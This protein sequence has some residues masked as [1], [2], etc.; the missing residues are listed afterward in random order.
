MAVAGIGAKAEADRSIRKTARLH[1]RIDRGVVLELGRLDPGLEI[2]ERLDAI[3]HAEPKGIRRDLL[4][5]VGK[6]IQRMGRPV[7]ALDVLT[8]D[9]VEPAGGP[10]LF[11]M[12][13][14]AQ[15]VAPIEEARV[16]RP[17]GRAAGFGLSWKIGEG[18]AA[19]ADAVLR[20]NDDDAFALFLQDHCSDQAGEAGADDHDID[21]LAHARRG[22]EDRLGKCC[23][24][25]E[26]EAGPA[27]QLNHWRRPAAR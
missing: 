3:E 6:G 21:I 22:G 18:V 10:I 5:R 20:L 25:D 4:V 16:H 13:L 9:V 26:S 24:T 17:D 11:R 23:G 27:C 8:F 12:A 1:Q 19:P 7:L 2:G 14:H 15:P